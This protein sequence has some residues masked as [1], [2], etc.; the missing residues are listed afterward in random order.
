MMMFDRNFELHKAFWSRQDIGRPLLG[1]NV[2]F[3]LQH[4][5]PRLMKTISPGPMKPEAIRTDLFLQ[6]CDNLYETHQ[7][8]GDYPFVSAPFVGIPW[9]EAIMGCPIMASPSSFWAE[10]YVDD[11]K[12]WHWQRPTIENPWAQKLLELMTA[13]VKHSNGRYPIAPTLMRGPSDIL[14]AMRGG[15]NLSLDIFDEPDLIRKVLKMCA[16]VHIEVGKAQL[17]EIPDSSQGYMAGDAALRTWAPNKVVWLQEDAMA[18]LSPSLYTEFISPVDKRISSEYSCTAFHLHG[19]AL[20]AIDELLQIPEIDVIELN[21]EDA[22][23][24]IEGTFEGW[25]KIQAHKPLVIWRMYGEDFEAWLKRVLREVPSNG[26]SIQISTNNNNEAEK[27]RQVFFE[28]IKR[29]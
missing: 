26:L 29:Y 10:H 6:D 7:N 23:C 25:K 9:M 24:D 14:A 5:F 16:D 8:L 27:T 2:G 28:V 20:W 18:L 17:A 22:S 12:N 4:R 21:L 15:A 1:I 19:S 13:L 11:W 3:T